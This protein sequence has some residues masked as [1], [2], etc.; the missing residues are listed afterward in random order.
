[1]NVVANRVMSVGES[2]D[3]AI[4]NIMQNGE[5]TEVVHSFKYLGS[6]SSSE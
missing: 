2:E 3:P 1:M 6:C 5:R 4:L